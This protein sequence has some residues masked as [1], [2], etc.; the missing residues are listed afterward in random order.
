MYEGYGPGGVGIFGGVCNRQHKPYFIPLYEQRLQSMVET[1]QRKALW[2]SYLIERNDS[3]K[4]QWRRIITTILDSG[5]EDAIEDDEETVVYT[6][7]KQLATVRNKLQG[8]K[9]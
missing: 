6:E 1:L 8:R 7:P 5:A 3:S 9:D 4:R 2:R